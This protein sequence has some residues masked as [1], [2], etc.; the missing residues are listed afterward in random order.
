MSPQFDLDVRWDT[1]RRAWVVKA[2]GVYSMSDDPAWSPKV[3]DVL[4]TKAEAITSAG[5][6]ATQLAKGFHTHTCEVYIYR[7]FGQ[8]SRWHDR[9]TYG[10]D[11]RGSKG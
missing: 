11:P 8:R 3:F 7:R 6:L 5:K 9:R 1:E 2:R 4:V 10:R